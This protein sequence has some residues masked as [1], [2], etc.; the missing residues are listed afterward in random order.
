M[1]IDRLLAVSQE[2]KWED[3]VE[4]F[5]KAIVAQAKA[6]SEKAKAILAL[7]DLKKERITQ[8][9]HSQYVIKILDSLF[10]RP[11]FST[12][13]FIRISGIPKRSALWLL[14]K[15]KREKIVTAIKAGRGRNPEI[16]AFNK[17]INIVA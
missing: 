6:N 13:D 11:I 10:K 4:F 3:W 15:L 9:T 1:N 5:L 7:Y 16:L 14:G 8:V 17:L 2:K 12:T